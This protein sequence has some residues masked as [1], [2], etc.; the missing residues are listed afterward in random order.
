MTLVCPFGK[1]LKDFGDLADGADWAVIYFVG[2]GMEIA[3]TNYLISVDAKLELQRHVE[4]EAMPLARV[5]GKVAGAGKMQLVILDA[6]RNNPFVAKMRQ[7]GRATRAISSGLASIEPESGVLVAYAA[8]DGTTALDG[9]ANSPFLEALVR[10]IGEPGLESICC[11]ARSATRC[12]RKPGASR[13]RSPMAR[14]P[15]SRSSSGVSAHL[16]SRALCR[17]ASISL[18]RACGRLDPG[19]KH[20]DDKAMRGPIRECGIGSTGREPWRSSKCTCG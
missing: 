18:L 7:S 4:D 16:S 3:G 15:P 2:H 6:C 1:V 14:C 19:A 9:E 13:S 11:S 10:H 5:L 20:R 12:W 17:D 8:R